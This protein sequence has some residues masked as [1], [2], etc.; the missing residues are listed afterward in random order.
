MEWNTIC[1]YEILS[2]ATQWM[3]GGPTWLLEPKLCTLK[4]L[5][6]EKT[7][8]LLSYSYKHCTRTAWS[9]HE[10]GW[11]PWD[12]RSS[13]LNWVPPE[14]STIHQRES[15]HKHWQEWKDGLEPSLDS[16]KKF[17]IKNKKQIY[18]ILIS[19]LE[20]IFKS[21]FFYPEYPTEII[22]FSLKHKFVSKFWYCLLL[23]ENCLLLYAKN[24]EGTHGR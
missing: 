13:R 15:N 21:A 14:R 5:H 1:I 16:W 9:K 6:K 23:F 10:Y 17:K 18:Q 22:K 24:L 8:E 4:I 7:M 11:Y 12:M 2:L 20:V 3:S 19:K